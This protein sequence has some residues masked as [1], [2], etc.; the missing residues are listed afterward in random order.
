MGL[1]L[2]ELRAAVQRHGPVARILVVD[3]KGSSPRDEGTAMLVWPSGQDGTIGGGTLEFR[4]V[5]EARRRLCEA[6]HAPQL[7]RYALGPALG[8]CCGG[9]VA[10]FCETYDAQ[11]VERLEGQA[12][13]VRPVAGTRDRHPAVDRIAGQMQ[14]N[15]GAYSG[16]AMAFGWIAEPIRAATRPIWVWGAG[17]V[18]RAVVAT[19]APLPEFAITWVDT[20]RDRFPRDVPAQVTILPAGEPD[21]LV[22]HAPTDAGHLILT[23]SHTL[24]L[25]LCHRLL[26]H[27]FGFAGLI[28]SATKWARFRAR[29][30]A[31]GHAP[32]R[33]DRIAC[34]IGD[35]SLGKHPQAIAVG[36]VAGL[37]QTRAAAADKEKRA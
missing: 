27:G 2:H 30:T 25:E 33:I 34:P 22:A 12:V 35:P 32:E 24:D 14:R 17:H 9:N 3:V 36:V 1:D 29:L 13:H 26:G 18:G 20:A 21:R 19:L 31:L 15:P 7:L 11:A 10:L 37:L 4:A 16:F 8:Q 23:Y 5:A 6:N 28:G